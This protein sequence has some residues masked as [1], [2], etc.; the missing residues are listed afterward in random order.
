[1]PTLMFINKESLDAIANKVRSILNIDSKFTIPNGIVS[2]IGNCNNFGKDLAL[3]KRFS[4]YDSRTECYRKQ[5]YGYGKYAF[6][7]NNNLTSVSLNSFNEVPDYCFLDCTN[8]ETVKWYNPTTQAEARQVPRG[9]G[10]FKGCTSLTSI[11]LAGSP[12]TNAYVADEAF[13]GCS[14][15]STISFVGTPNTY[16]SVGREAFLNCVSLTSYNGLG[17][18]INTIG[19]SAFRGSGLTSIN[20]TKTSGN[21]LTINDYAFA[22]CPDMETVSITFNSGRTVLGNYCFY[23]DTSLTTVSLPTGLTR[24]PD[25]CFDGCSSLTSIHIPASVTSIGEYA[26]N[27]CTSLAEI[28]FDGTPTIASIGQRAFMNCDSL[29]NFTVPASVTSIG[30]YAFADCDSLEYTR[31]LPTT[32]PTAGQ[33]IFYTTINNP[34]TIY[35]PAS[36]DNVVYNA[37]YNATNWKISSYRSRMAIWPES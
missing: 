5:G 37:Y 4:T 7:G 33:Y 16:T 32:P 25:H 9:I 20:I 21:T 29:V 6:A 36:A 3:G 22:E 30:A 23:N 34:M 12:V 14:S 11:S 1:M 19:E 35:V 28:V 18:Y 31:L 26:F 15:L 27:G 10:C 13:S 8:L 17:G 24:I 2:A